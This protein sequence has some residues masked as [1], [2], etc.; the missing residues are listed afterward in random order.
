MLMVAVPVVVTSNFSI[1]VILLVVRV[2]AR[3]A[4]VKV[5]VPVPPASTSLE[6]HV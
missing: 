2:E 3:I 6:A 5:S 1:P 4:A